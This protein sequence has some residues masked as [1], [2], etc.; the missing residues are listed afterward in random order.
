MFGHRKGKKEGKQD[1]K[2]KESEVEKAK[3]SAALWE[4][5]L[6]AA[7]LSLVQHREASRKLAR[8]NEEL[9]SQLHRQERD[10]MDVTGYLKRQD[11]AKEDEVCLTMYV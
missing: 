11:A 4:L 9:T 7:D 10:A 8:A 5:R 6:Q 1:S 3:A 2:D